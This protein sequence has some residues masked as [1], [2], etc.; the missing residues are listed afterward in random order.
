M[1][2]A[3]IFVGHCD[4]TF[5]RSIPSSDDTVIVALPFETAVKIPFSLT[6][7]IDSSELS[8]QPCCHTQI[9]A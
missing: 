3:Q 4:F 6:F 8:M 7:T 9:P 1:T 2:V 5:V